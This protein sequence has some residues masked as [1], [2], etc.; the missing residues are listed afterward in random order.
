[1]AKGFGEKKV[2]KRE[3]SAG[4]IKREEEAS[5]YDE[6]AA[7]GGQEYNIYVRQFGS[8]DQSWFPCGSIAVPRGA[9]VTDA[10]YANDEALK[11][12]IVRTYPKL[13]GFEA[14]FEFG[15]NL[16]IYPDDPVRR[17]SPKWR[18]K[19][20][21]M[22]MTTTLPPLLLRRKTKHRQAQKRS[23]NPSPSRPRGKRA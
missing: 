12:A 9:Q 19:R 22:L 15:Y 6:L 1:M 3:K 11:V 16:K 2:Q 13:E 18:R 10:I 23:P 17:S 4:Q 20:V 7:S 21:L 14:E 8:D 5:K